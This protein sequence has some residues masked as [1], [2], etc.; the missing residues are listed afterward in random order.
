MPI[1]VITRVENTVKLSIAEMD[2]NLTDL[3]D[4]VNS[5]WNETVDITTDTSLTN[6][7]VALVDATAAIV[8][9]TLPPVA[10]NKDAEFIIKK[11]DGSINNVIIATNNTDVIEGTTQITLT[12]QWETKRIISNGVSWYVI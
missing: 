3:Q 9:V 2:K 10:T 7:R 4:G 11:I 1:N 5:A 6:L 8:T 12:T